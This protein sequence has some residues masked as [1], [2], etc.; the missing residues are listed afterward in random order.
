MN[1]TSRD[2]DDLSFEE[3]RGYLQRHPNS[4]RRITAKPKKMKKQK[5]L[6]FEGI[7]IGTK[8][9]A[10][11]FQ[12]S[13]SRPDSYLEGTIIGAKDS[14]H[15]MYEVQVEKDIVHGQERPIDDV[16]TVMQV[17]MEVAFME[18]DNRIQVLPEKTAHT[19]EAR[20][21]DDMT[22]EDQKGYL[23]RHP[24]SKRKI[25][26]K[27]SSKNVPKE[28]KKKEKKTKKPTTK[29]KSE[30]KD[31]VGI[32]RLDK[33]LS[34]LSKFSDK[35][36]DLNRTKLF[37]VIK[38]AVKKNKMLKGSKP[39]TYGMWDH[40][41]AKKAAEK[42]DGMVNKIVTNVNKLS[43][44][45]HNRKDDILHYMKQQFVVRG[46]IKTPKSVKEMKDVKPKK[47][48]VKKKTKTPDY[49]A[50]GHRVSFDSRKGGNIEGTVTNIK[51]GR[52]WNKIEVETDD[53][54]HWWLKSTAQSYNDPKLNLKF[55]GNTSD[56]DTQRLV[57]NRRDFENAMHRSKV[58]RKE[59][60]RSK[61]EDLD[62]NTGDTIK[63]KGTSYDWDAKVVSVDYRKGGVRID[64][65]RTRRQRGGLFEPG[66]TTQHYR[67]IPARS[68]LSKV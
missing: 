16:N 9:K 19:K 30:V 41:D 54:Q 21:W 1:K 42:L 2:W 31:M 40:G 33:R 3:Q 15:K 49:V 47:S 25:T 64:Q 65:V 8:I 46:D 61:L 67:F 57:D 32:A 43:D 26:A 29:T 23:K 68:I 34:G 55:H 7:P 45:Y 52:K 10:Y 11:H 13:K 24:K 37:W 62:I 59:D 27:P 5:K 53:G 63:I 35:H 50:V 36:Y 44:K 14:P 6:K 51:S 56:D 12:P 38:N 39:K 66:K 4:K 60:N 17:P 22:L 48:K 18:F 58:Q 20:K 28:K